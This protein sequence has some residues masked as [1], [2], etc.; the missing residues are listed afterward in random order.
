V[1]FEPVNVVPVVAG[2]VGNKVWDWEWWV[3]FSDHVLCS[4]IVHVVY[5]ICAVTCKLSVFILLGIS[6]YLKKGIK[7]EED[8]EVMAIS[9][10]PR[11]V[12]K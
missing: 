3:H 12:Q 6:L 8:S 2:K 10:L 5:N 1:D 7:K 9:V 4:C 11:Y